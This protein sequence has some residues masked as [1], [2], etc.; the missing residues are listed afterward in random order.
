VPAEPAAPDS[1]RRESDDDAEDGEHRDERRSGQNL[2]KRVGYNLG[3]TLLLLPVHSVKHG[4]GVTSFQ[5]LVFSSATKRIPN[6]NQQP[7]IM[8]YRYPRACTNKVNA[9]AC[10]SRTRDEGMQIIHSV[11]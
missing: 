10:L 11:L 8:G 7:N 2:Q 4:F 6:L 5:Q 9:K 3:Q 1:V